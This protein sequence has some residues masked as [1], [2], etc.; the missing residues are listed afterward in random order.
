MLRIMMMLLRCNYRYSLIYA[1]VV[2]WKR[3]HRNEVAKI[4]HN[5]LI[6][7]NGNVCDLLQKVAIFLPLFKLFVLYTTVHQFPIFSCSPASDFSCNGRCAE[8]VALLGQ[9]PH[10][11]FAFL[12]HFPY[13]IQFSF[14]L[15]SVSWSANGLHYSG[16][17]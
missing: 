11:P 5:F 7:I 8:K 17:Y 2:F 13:S 3:S 12:Q 15:K 6:K 9:I 4:E 1:T 16:C 10:S 14:S